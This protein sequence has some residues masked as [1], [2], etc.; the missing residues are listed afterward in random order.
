M[1]KLKFGPQSERHSSHN[2]IREQGASQFFTF[3]EIKPGLAVIKLEPKGE[4]E[5]EL[6]GALD[7]GPDGEI[8]PLSLN[9]DRAGPAV[10]QED[11]PCPLAFLAL[12][13]N[14]EDGIWGSAAATVKVEID[15]ETR[16]VHL[17]EC[18]GVGMSDCHIYQH[19]RQVGE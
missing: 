2:I 4:T 19:T 10:E 3:K 15:G 17:E 12:E 1:D 16:E 6:D 9:T 8:D 14:T 5:L 11:L 13:S 7:P 18:N